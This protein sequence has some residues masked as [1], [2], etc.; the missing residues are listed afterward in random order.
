MTSRVT[1]RSRYVAQARTRFGR[2]VDRL[3]WASTHGIQPER[4]LAALEATDL[5]WNVLFDARSLAAIAD[6]TMI[7][8]VEEQAKKLLA[9]VRARRLGAK[10]A[11][12]E[13]RTPEEAALFRAKADALQAGAS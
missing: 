4:D 10:L 8:E 3:L 9:A 6:T 2:A 1:E 13:G 11:Q 5:L 12:T 7:D